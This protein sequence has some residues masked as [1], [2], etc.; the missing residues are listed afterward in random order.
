MMS[1]EEDLISTECNGD[2]NAIIIVEEMKFNISSI[3]I[4]DDIENEEFY[5]ELEAILNSTEESKDIKKDELLKVGIHVDVVSDEG[6][7][8]DSD[9]L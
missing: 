7:E 2:V 5:E 9:S 3:S 6:N 4:H 8:G 1:D